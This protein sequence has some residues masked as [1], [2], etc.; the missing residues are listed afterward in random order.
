MI[1][2]ELER[3]S[4]EREEHLTQTLRSTVIPAR[5]GH[6]LDSCSGGDGMRHLAG[7]TGRT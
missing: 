4:V 1:V 5:D 3:F 6:G 7:D 2:E